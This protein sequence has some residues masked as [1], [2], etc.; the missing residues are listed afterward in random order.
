MN[1]HSYPKTIQ[2]THSNKKKICIHQNPLE[3]TSDRAMVQNSPSLKGLRQMME[4]LKNSPIIPSFPDDG[5]V[6]E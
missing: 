1:C 4:M 3:Q 6:K 2:S 5:N